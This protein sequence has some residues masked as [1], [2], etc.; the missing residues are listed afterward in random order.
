MPGESQLGTENATRRLATDWA[1]RFFARNELEVRV[2][3]R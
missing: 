3:A 2:L 1:A